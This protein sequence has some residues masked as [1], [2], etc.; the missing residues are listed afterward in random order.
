[1]MFVISEVHPFRDGNGRI[2]RVMMNAE[3]VAE[4]QGKI[5]IP[6]VY[7]DDY[8]GVL[9]KLSQ[10]QVIA[11]YIRML[12][13]ANDFSETIYGDDR[14]E[15]Q[16]Y[17]EKCNAFRKS[18]DWKLKII[19]RPSL[20]SRQTKNKRCSRSSVFRNCVK[21]RHPKPIVFLIG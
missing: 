5:I 9:K 10:Q 15:M 13:R 21:S 3:L 14:D 1:M 6:A 12:Q 17:L 4:G 2:A 8:M 19:S 7:R 16:K 11:P 18:K 20:R